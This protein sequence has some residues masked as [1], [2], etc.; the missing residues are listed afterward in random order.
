M[1]ECCT[2]PQVKMKS[3]W[4]GVCPKSHGITVWERRGRFEYRE[5]EDAHMTREAA[6]AVAQ[7][8]G[9]TA[10]GGGQGGLYP[11]AFRG[12]IALPPAWLQNHSPRNCE[13]IHF[14]CCKPTSLQ[15]L[16]LAAS[17]SEYRHPDVVQG[18]LCSL[19]CFHPCLLRTCSTEQADHLFQ[20]LI[21]QII[22]CSEPSS[23]FSE[24]TPLFFQWQLSLYSICYKMLIPHSLCS[25]HLAS[26]LL[27]SDA[28]CFASGHLHLLFP[29]SRGN[30]D[31]PCSGMTQSNCWLESWGPSTAWGVRPSFSCLLPA[32]VVPP[33]SA[34]MFQHFNNLFGLADLPGWKLASA[35]LHFLF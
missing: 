12:G 1:C 32:E 15:W 22:P 29:W 13:R 33:N 30:T 11:G 34:H 28:R 18:Y 35:L 23:G 16:V 8:H 20:N 3:E 7:P 25:S 26:C 10:A 4:M 24:Q 19:D 21:S 31:P 14:C 27:V 9:A 2:D 17:G 5:R 6:M